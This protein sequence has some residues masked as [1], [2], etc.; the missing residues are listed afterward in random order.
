MDTNEFINK[1]NILHNNE[2]GY[3]RTIFVN[4]LSKVIITCM[5]HGDFYKHQI[6]ICGNPVQLV[7]PRAEK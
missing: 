2:C 4:S 3:L 1:A 5:I 6:I 7:A